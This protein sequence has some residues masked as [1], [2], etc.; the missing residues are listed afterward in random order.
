VV[1]FCAKRH[2]EDTWHFFLLISD[3]VD[4]EKNAYMRV[5]NVIRRMPKPFWIG[6]LNMKLLSPSAPLALGV[7]ENLPK[8]DDMPYWY[9]RS[10]LG[11]ASVEGIFVYPHPIP[12]S[13]IL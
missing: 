10:W 13:P 8:S 11:N 12:T 1:G 2:E 5:Q 3:I 9:G 7:L 6:L 4:G